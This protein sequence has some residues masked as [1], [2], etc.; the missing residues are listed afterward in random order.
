MITWLLAE[1]TAV[2][3]CFYPLKYQQDDLFILSRANHLHKITF[4]TSLI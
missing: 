3:I 2:K 4:P 1:Y